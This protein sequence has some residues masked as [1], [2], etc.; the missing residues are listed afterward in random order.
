METKSTTE[1]V[2]VSFSQRTSD[3]QKVA[4]IASDTTDSKSRIRPI[5]SSILEEKYF[6]RDS[7]RDKL[8]CSEN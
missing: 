3:E 2:S 5:G 1:S 4:R 7:Q 6:K 8:S